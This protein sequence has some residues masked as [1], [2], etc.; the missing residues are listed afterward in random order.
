MGSGWGHR[1]RF[2]PHV[3]G[4]RHTIVVL[5]DVPGDGWDVVE[6]LIRN[7]FADATVLSSRA[8]KALLRGL[9]PILCKVKTVEKGNM[10]FVEMVLRNVLY[11]W[12]GLN[13]A[14]TTYNDAKKRNF[15]F[16]HVIRVYRVV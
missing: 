7:G 13:L 1:R 6:Y 14:P 4:Y 10:S 12:D 3:H 8:S 2:D 5:T 11:E 9:E 16:G 15:L